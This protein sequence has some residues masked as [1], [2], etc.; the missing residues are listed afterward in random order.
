MT[1]ALFIAIEEQESTRRVWK[2]S[3]VSD[4]SNVQVDEA[5]LD[6]QNTDEEGVFISKDALEKAGQE[7]KQE[8]DSEANLARRKRS[9]S[10]D[11]I[12]DKEIEDIN[13]FI[14]LHPTEIRTFEIKLVPRHTQL[15]TVTVTRTKGKSL[16]TMLSFVS[17]VRCDDGLIRSRLRAILTVFYRL[18]KR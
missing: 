6:K 7:V 10:T 1:H 5:Q 11:D 8:A 15:D 3:G 9:P 17:C 2:S 14:T 18:T 16:F 4:L 13:S 12:K